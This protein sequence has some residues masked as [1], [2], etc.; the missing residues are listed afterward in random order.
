VTEPVR[1]LIADDRPLFRDG[2]IALLTDR[3][4]C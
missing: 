1:V 2:L 4:G 3:P